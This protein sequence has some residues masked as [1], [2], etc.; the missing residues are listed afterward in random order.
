MPDIQNN[1]VQSKMN[2]DLDDRLIPKGQYRS[3]QNVAISRSQGED[4]GA[5]ENI[6]GNNIITNSDLASIPHLDV[7]G[8]FVDTSQNNVYLF[9]TDYIDTSASGI[10]NFAPSTANCFIYKFNNE[11]NGT[12]TKLVEGS[13]L[14]F[15]KNSPI[16][17]ISMIENLL[18]FTDYRNQPRKINVTT[19]AGNNTYYQNEDQISVAK[20]APV[21]PVRFVD[22]AYNNKLKSTISN[23]SQEFLPINIAS[24][25]SGNQTI[26]NQVT[27]DNTGFTP[28]V[29]SRIISIGALALDEKIVVT[30]STTTTI[31]FSPTLS[32]AVNV[33]NNE[34][35][36]F[37]APNPD[38][39]AD[40]AG[41]PDYVKDRFIRFSYR[42]KFDDGEYSIMAPFSQSCFVPKQSGY[43]ISS[44]PSVDGNFARNDADQTYRSTVV[45][46]MEN[47]A[48]QVDLNIEMPYANIE[49][50][51]KVTEVE[52]L[53]KESDQV[54]IKSVESIPIEAV[55][56][57]MQ[58]NA[59]SNVFTYK[60]LSTK[61]YKVLPEDQ[62]TR[63]YDKVPVRAFS[64]ETSSNRIIY[65]NFID[66]H[67][68]PDSLTYGLGFANKEKPSTVGALDPNNIYSQIE[69]PN[70]TLKQNRNYQ[71]GVVLA[72][73][74]GRS[75]TTILSSKDVSTDTGSGVPYGNSTIY[76]PYA[77]WGSPSSTI[78]TNEMY[79]WPG[80]SLSV[81]FNNKEGF[82]S[83]IPTVPSD[84][85]PGTYVPIGAVGAIAIN[86]GGTGYSD[87]TNVATTG[88]SGTG[89]TVDIT[90]TAG[91][92]TNIEI[93]KMGEDY[94]DGDTIT[95]TG[96][97]GNATA[98][99]TLAEPNL[100]GWYSYKFVVRQTEQDYYNV[101][102]PGIL[103]GY[104][105]QSTS[106]LRAPFEVH[107]TSNIVLF[108]DNINKIPRDLS[109]V[110]PDQKIFQSSVKLFGRVEPFDNTTSTSVVQYNPPNTPIFAANISTL[111]EANY[112][113]NIGADL[114]YVTFYNSEAN[115]YIARLNTAKKI[116]KDE[117]TTSSNFGISLSILETE[118]V[119]SAL[120][121][122]WETTTAGLVEDLN[123]EVK[124]ASSSTAPV[125][126][127]STVAAQNENFPINTDVFGSLSTPINAIDS[128][129]QT[130]IGQS[131]S[132]I[133]STRGNGN[134]L[135]AKDVNNSSVDPFNIFASGNGF[136]IQTNGFF[137]V[138]T[139]AVEN[140]F[141]ITIRVTDNTNLTFVDFVVSW[142]LGNTP[143]SFGATPTFFSPINTTGPIA[144]SD[145]SVNAVNG[146]NSAAS[147]AQRQ[148]D[149]IF[150]IAADTVENSL[151]VVD[152]S[153]NNYGFSINSTGT[154]L[155]QNGPLLPPNDTYTIPIILRDAGGLT[156]THNQD[157]QVTA[158]LATTFALNLSNQTGG[159]YTGSMDFEVDI[160]YGGSPTTSTPVTNLQ[161]NVIGSP[162]NSMDVKFATLNPPPTNSNTLTFDITIQNSQP[163]F[164][165]PPGTT[166]SIEV[167]AN[168]Q[169]ASSLILSKTLTQNT[170][171]S[172]TQPISLNPSNDIT[173]TDLTTSTSL[174]FS[175]NIELL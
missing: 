132:I 89:L 67:S 163:T 40:W 150:S 76:V 8:Y 175:V 145:Y 146:T 27:I 162:S 77:S 48:T 9:Y 131:F 116:G 155:S 78:N 118:A 33:L 168:R 2:Q 110:G 47:N 133:S 49:T 39:D 75:S 134:A 153:G 36:S 59:N 169:S 123:L 156:A 88:G 35:I 20:F 22:M 44:Q 61:P 24:T 113:N 31:N 92:I 38:Y 53:Y 43:F 138:S 143:P 111:A 7:I 107:E 91:V 4:V 151:N 141:N 29:G 41:D 14:N 66:K 154:S 6:E 85:Y 79:K 72:D 60:Y 147:L 69:Y 106:A 50:N 81:L 152:A 87:A 149:L 64:Q 12:F 98:T 86:A 46:F 97:G 55:N 115:P 16:Y 58:A 120:D 148:E 34:D 84:G 165:V 160:T 129:G 83:A 108:N 42:F 71:L 73:R 65:G 26:T 137:N 28:I 32:P 104:P 90:V 21:N 11:G 82:T 45:S 15:S 51:L 130:V 144:N 139:N 105:H 128:S 17:G 117:P 112:K 119:E 126:L 52:I 74:Y 18:F 37:E 174:G 103:S 164:F 56:T 62:T 135:L 23:P 122:Y 136:Y 171:I 100:L 102:L 158:G 80:Y 161:T 159:T 121:I 93:A 173:G 166:L 70:H 54:A 95:V 142:T 99:I 3:A 30:G 124:Q 25:V 140:N 10:D 13:F 5:L 57:N 63:V 19:A 109:E 157:I 172:T 101:Y 167:Y 125:A 94:T 114:E 68:S 170:P 96:G 1:F 127:S